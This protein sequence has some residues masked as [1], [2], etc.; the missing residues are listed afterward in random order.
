MRT[1]SDSHTGIRPTIWPRLVTKASRKC[2]RT[3]RAWFLVALLPEEV[4][5][6]KGIG[7]GERRCGRQRG[8]SGRRA[9]VRPGPIGPDLGSGRRAQER[10]A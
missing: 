4:A 1:V 7:G 10:F 6:H 8:P 3:A 2:L 5:R 9:Q